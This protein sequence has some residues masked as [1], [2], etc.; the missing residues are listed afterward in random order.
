MKL[1]I[2]RS[3]AA[4]AT[5]E[6]YDLPEFQLAL[7]QYQVRSAREHAVYTLSVFDGEQLVEY[8]DTLPEC[9]D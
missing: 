3:G 5:R 6:I 9:C 1:V 7:N 8:A 4:Y 2:E